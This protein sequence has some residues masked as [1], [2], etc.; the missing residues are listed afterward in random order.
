[1]LDF[2]KIIM[3]IIISEIKEGDV[4][5]TTGEYGEPCRISMKKEDGKLEGHVERYLIDKSGN[6]VSIE[7]GKQDPE[8]GEFIIDCKYSL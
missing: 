5:W 8:T 7:V 1:M 4:I 2:I 6:S 3:K